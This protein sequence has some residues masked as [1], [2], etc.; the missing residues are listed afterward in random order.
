MATKMR[1]KITVWIVITLEPLV[2]EH[3]P[4]IYTL[5]PESQL[6]AYGPA[7]NDEFGY[8]PAMD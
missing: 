7:A 3:C 4:L 2:D 1:Q 6:L 8:L 5:Q